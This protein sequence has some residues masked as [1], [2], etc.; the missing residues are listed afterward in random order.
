M[1]LYGMNFDYLGKGRAAAILSMLLVLVSLG[2][3]LFKGMNFGIDFT[4]G[5]L[6]EA[7]YDRPV[8][9]EQIRALLSKAGFEGQVQHFGTAS[10]VIIRL[11]TIEGQTAAQ[12]SEKILGA[13]RVD[14]YQVELKRLEF[15]GPQVGEELTVQG[16]QAVAWVA[17][18]I[19]IYIYFRFEWRFAV[20]GVITLLH[21]VIV[22]VG[23]L[24]LFQLEFDLVVLASV[25]AA[26]GYSLNDSIVVFDRIRENFLRMR[27]ATPAE[28][29]NSS[30]N[31]TLT[32]SIITGGTTLFVLIALYFWGGDVLKGFSLAMIVGIIVGTYS[33]LFIAPYLVLRMGVTKA[34]LMPPEKEGVEAQR[35]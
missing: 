17:I 15:V 23:F 27:K 30:V 2:S 35:P 13:L 22:T 3:F 7:S 25:M 26:A 16:L 1:N 24:S 10:D 19:L 32:R 18:G 11:P 12:L 14:G 34:D 8:E 29:I 6:V 33:S 31:Q 9:L 4:G 28:V 5:T 21:D 20:N